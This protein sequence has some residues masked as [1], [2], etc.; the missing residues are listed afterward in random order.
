MRRYLELLRNRPFATLWAGS[1][2]SAVGD[3]LTWVA[4][5]WLVIENGSTR[6]VGGLV[7]ASTAPVIAGG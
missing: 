5:V 4:L 6:A 2:V 1:T 7:V 3:A